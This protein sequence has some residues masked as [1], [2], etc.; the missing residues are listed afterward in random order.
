MIEAAMIWN[1]PNHRSHRDVQLDPG[2]SRFADMARLALRRDGAPLRPVIA[3]QEAKRLG[4]NQP[5][6]GQRAQR[7]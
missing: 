5:R 7:G 1:E 4:A 6:R 2:W 3:I